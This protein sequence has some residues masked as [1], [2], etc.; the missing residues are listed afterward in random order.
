MEGRKKLELTMKITDS[1]VKLSVIASSYADYGAKETVRKFNRWVDETHNLLKM[2]FDVA[3]LEE[4]KNLEKPSIWKH[5]PDD[6]NRFSGE[7][8]DYLQ[9]L[10]EDIK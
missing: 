3:K 10:I 8:A 2:N 7:H 1:V 9:G 5:S 6:I 4:F